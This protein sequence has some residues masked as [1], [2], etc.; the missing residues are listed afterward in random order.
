MQN[1]PGCNYLKLK[2]MQNCVENFIRP[3]DCLSEGS[4]W[5]ERFLGA[6]E[7]NRN[8]CVTCAMGHQEI[9]LMVRM[10]FRDKYLEQKL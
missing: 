7:L 9:Y 5:Q 6:D 4:A 10:G 1:K 3:S 8:E 2:E